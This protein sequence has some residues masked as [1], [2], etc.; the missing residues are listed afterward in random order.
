MR[1]GQAARDVPQA[2]RVVEQAEHSAGEQAT[3]RISPKPCVVSTPGPEFPFAVP[4]LPWQSSI[5]LWRSNLLPASCPA[6]PG[7]LLP[8]CLQNRK[9][10]GFGTSF[11]QCY[12]SLC[13]EKYLFTSFCILTEEA[14]WVP[15]AC[16][17]NY[18]SLSRYP[19]P[20]V[21][22]RNTQ[23]CETGPLLF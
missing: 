23:Q 19:K 16:V 10:F 8:E 11:S 17:P 14:V 6:S 20:H 18:S 22:F 12:V 21:P 4:A 5:V 3:L 9:G 15:K 7:Q 1:A 2:L 13:T